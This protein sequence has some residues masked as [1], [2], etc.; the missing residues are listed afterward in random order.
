M[1]WFNHQV[2][3]FFPGSQPP[4]L[5]GFNELFLIFNDRKTLAVPV[6]EP[7]LLG[8]PGPFKPHQQNRFCQIH[9]EILRRKCWNFRLQLLLKG[10][11]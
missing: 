3:N 6:F 1:G 7:K 9:P 2:D 5:K 10:F 4:F 11:G 8:L